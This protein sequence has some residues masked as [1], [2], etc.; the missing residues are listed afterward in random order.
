M[1]IRVESVVNMRLTS[2]GKVSV[3]MQ[4]MAVI[5]VPTHI[6]NFSVRLTLDQL[7]AP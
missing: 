5:D 4:P 2:S 7:P 1:S 6:P 3:M